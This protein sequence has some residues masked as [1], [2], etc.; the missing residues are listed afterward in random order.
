MY[1]AGLT[2]TGKV[3]SNNQDAIFFT[4]E[5]IGP[6]PNLY[7]VADGMGGHNAGEVASQ[8]TVEVIST[9]IRNFQAAEF[10]RHDCFLDLLVSAAQ[11]ANTTVFTKGE[12]YPSMKGMGTTLI[13]C[14]ISE[15][16]VFMVHVGDSRAYSISSTSI[17]QLTTDHT[18]VEGLLQAGRITLEESKTHPRRHVITR[19]LGTHAIC[20]VDGIVHNLADTSALLLCS[21]GLS[22]MLDDKDLMTI[23]NREGYVEQRVQTLIQEANNRG[24]H[25]NISAIL[26]DVSR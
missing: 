8:Q 15:G 20:E 11:E 14:S 19:V 9:Y 4:N 22:N 13:A 5:P 1:V 16:K 6:L 2:H 23:I 26:V 17:T 25:D 10:I 21:D 7:V 18:V 3:R 12:L 24:G